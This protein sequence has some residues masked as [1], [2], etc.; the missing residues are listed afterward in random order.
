MTS[1]P[2]NQPN[3]PTTCDKQ[4]NEAIRRATPTYPIRGHVQQLRRV[5]PP[6]TLALV[7]ARAAVLR[8]AIPAPQEDVCVAVLSRPTGQPPHLPQTFHERQDEQAR[9][10]ND[11]KRAQDCLALRLFVGQ[12]NLFKFVQVCSS[13][14][15]SYKLFKALNFVQFC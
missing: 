5:K 6:P 15:K 1:P 10:Q 3:Q 4:K 14:F 7:V 13:L 2:T 12:V 9:R 11:E 8:L